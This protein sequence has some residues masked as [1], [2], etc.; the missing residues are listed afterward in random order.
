M[1]LLVVLFYLWDRHGT[2]KHVRKVHPMTW[3]VAAASS[4]F[5]LNMIA[6]AIHLHKYSE[7]GVGYPLLKQIGRW[8]NVSFQT[9][10]SV[11]LV[12]IAK[13]WNVSSDDLKGDRQSLTVIRTLTQNLNSQPQAISTPK[14]NRVPL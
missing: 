1:T 13:G 4:F 10:F 3:W 12:A 2:S 7:D 11:I 8:M 9:G 14:C 6:H 5:T